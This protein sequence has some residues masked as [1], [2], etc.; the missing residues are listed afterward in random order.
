VN[1]EKNTHMK[2]SFVHGILSLIAASALVI[3]G[4]GNSDDSGDTSSQAGSGG[5]SDAGAG[6]AAAGAGGSAAGAGGSTAGAGGSTAG[7]GGAAAGSGGAAAGAGGAAVGAGGAAAGAGGAA[8]GAGGAA[9]ATRG[10]TLSFSATGFSPHV[11]GLFEVA[12]TRKDTS[13]L[14][15]SKAFAKLPTA[16]FALTWDGLLKAGVEYSVDYYGDLS[17]NTACDAPPTDHV[18][19]RDIAAVTDD[20]A[21]AVSHDPKWEDKCA[22][23]ATVANRRDLTFTGQGFDVHN[24]VRFEVVV[25]R[26]DNNAV[27]VHAVSDSL[28]T[29]ASGAF[30]Y[31][32]PGLLEVGKAYRVDYFADVNKNGTCDA[33]PADHVWHRDVT[34]VSDDVALA[35]THDT[36]WVNVCPSFQ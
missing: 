18:W 12:V 13:E 21:L 25:S 22:S 27:L 15:A 35:V 20:V 3:A 19:H 34:S 36:T 2:P 5:S 31:T 30:S 33:P 14:V 26:A 16:D 6:G 17:K 32:W 28:D 29:G 11:D 7:A 8:A 10:Y 24:G 23:F 4:C 1:P 9:A